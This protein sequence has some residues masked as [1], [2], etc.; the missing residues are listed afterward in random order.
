MMT[1]P[2][3]DRPSCPNFLLQSSTA[4]AVACASDFQQEE[5]PSSCPAPAAEVVARIE[6]Q[7]RTGL[8]HYLRTL[9]PGCGAAVVR[10]RTKH[11]LSQSMTARVLGSRFKCL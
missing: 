8:P 5:F 6:G 1:K 3:P 2:R 7:Q 4:R 10:P 11:D 9:V